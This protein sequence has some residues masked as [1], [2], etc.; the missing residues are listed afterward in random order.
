MAENKDSIHPF[1][2][3]PFGHGA[4][5]CIG[6]RYEDMVAKLLLSKMVFKYH[7]SMCDE[8]PEELDFTATN[9]EGLFTTSHDIFLKF[10]LSSE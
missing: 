4:R 10:E 9:D 5:N 8:S 1:S 6:Q 2:F 7:I 3:L